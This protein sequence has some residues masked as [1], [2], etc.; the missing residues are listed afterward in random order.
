LFIQRAQAV[1]PDF[2]ITNETA[3]AVAE[4]CYQLDG[5]PLAIE[6]AAARIKL[7]SPQALLARLKSRL[8]VLTS[9]ARDLP[10]RQQTLRS[11]IDWSYNLLSDQAKV[12]FR[13]LSVFSGGLTLD[14]AEAVCNSEGDL[15]GDV[16]DEIEVL[17]DDC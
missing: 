8:D 7:F 10:A 12:L 6:L 16:L 11:A 17:V 13:R 5:L 9:G 15:G 1:K 4:I 3:P 14:A 2:A